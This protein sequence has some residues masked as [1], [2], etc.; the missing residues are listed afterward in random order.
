MKEIEISTDFIKLD[1]FLKW[2]GIATLG[3]EA[4]MYIYDEL[5]KVNG[6]VCIQ[7]GKK[8]RKGDVVSFNGEDYKII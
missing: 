4:K 3:S 6:D 1:A 2:C 7:R 5:V 8:L